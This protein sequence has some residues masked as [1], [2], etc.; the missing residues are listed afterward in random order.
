MDHRKTTM[1]GLDRM[2]LKVRTVRPFE[3][4]VAGVRLKVWRNPY[5]KLA[6]L[7]RGGNA[8]TEAEERA[9]EVVAR[10]MEERVLRYLGA[11]WSVERGE[12]W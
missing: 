3:A 6:V 9:V 4:T 5:T 7:E 12:G 10:W 1:S 11:G 2:A 8:A